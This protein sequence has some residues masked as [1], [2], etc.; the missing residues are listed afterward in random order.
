M[1]IDLKHVTVRIRGGTAGQFIDVKIGNGNITYDEKRNMDYIKDRGLLDTVRE[2]DQEPIDVRLDAEWDYI[3][4]DSGD[5]QPTIED[6]LK[7][8][9][10][11][12]SW[13]SSSADPCEPYAVDLVLLNV[14]ACTGAGND[15][16]TIILSDFRYESIGHD[17]KASQL[18]IAGK[19]NTTQAVPTRGAV[20]SY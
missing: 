6:A 5:T 2:G 10:L 14:P 16:E 12:S 13:D 20:Q 18:A 9:G 17:P 11:A 4:S 8:R 19:C 1:V 7:H 3:T 15:P